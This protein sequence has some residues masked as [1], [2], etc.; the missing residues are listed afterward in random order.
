MIVGLYISL[1]V[2]ETVV[3]RFYFFIIFF[4]NML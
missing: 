3:K 4:S 1:R 2:L